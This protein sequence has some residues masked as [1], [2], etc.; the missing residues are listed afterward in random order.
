MAVADMVLFFGN[1]FN[2][3]IDIA[4]QISFEVLLIAVVGSKPL[5]T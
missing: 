4:V 2:F 3:S 5:A 1:L